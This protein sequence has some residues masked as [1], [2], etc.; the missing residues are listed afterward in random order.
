MQGFIQTS[1]GLKPLNLTNIQA[2]SYHVA[3]ALPFENPD[4][5]GQ[6][7]TGTS[8][9]LV[10]EYIGNTTGV[11]TSGGN[12]IVTTDY[13]SNQDWVVRRFWDWVRDVNA[14]GVGKTLNSYLNGKPIYGVEQFATTN[15]A[16][17]QSFGIL[18][19]ESTPIT[20]VCS[21]VFEYNDSINQY[22]YQTFVTNVYGTFPEYG[23]NVFLD[24]NQGYA[25][26]DGFVKNAEVT[27]SYSKAPADGYYAWLTGNPAYSYYSFEFGPPEQ[28]TVDQAG[29]IYKVR[30]QDGKVTSVEICPADFDADD[31]VGDID[32][33]VLP[34]Y[35]SQPP[36]YGCACYN[37]RTVQPC[38]M[39]GNDATGGGWI[40]VKL[41][42]TEIPGP[43]AVIPSS[44]E[45]GPYVPPTEA[46]CPNFSGE[47][48]MDML[49]SM[50]FA[51][52]IPLNAK[53]WM[54]NKDGQY[55]LINSN[56]AVIS[57]NNGNDLSYSAIF[58][59]VKVKESFSTTISAVGEGYDIPVT[60]EWFTAA[61]DFDPFPPAEEFENQG[62]QFEFSAATSRV[63]GFSSACPL[64]GGASAG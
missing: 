23:A 60:C 61:T 2:V 15:L 19:E 3:A 12:I 1:V 39:M 11:T 6:I 52:G 51:A 44:E 21:K 42:F 50:Q 59:S 8:G 5:P 10:V 27:S 45:E 57:D 22:T 41:G 46:Q 35:L 14:G 64:A 28:V 26:G 7:L 62:N 58:N 29:E 56:W 30:I 49:S 54:Q 63:T 37:T 13:F 47:K 33:A 48:A 55:V 20:D 40:D 43:V 17:Q 16:P 32:G 18:I 4:N 25:S 31:A 24:A 53:V 36:A 34:A 9:S 38:N